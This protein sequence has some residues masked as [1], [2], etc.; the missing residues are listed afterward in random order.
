MIIVTGAE[1]F[2]GSCLVARLNQ[3]GFSDIVLV[4]DFGAI[5]GREKNI[6]GKN[7]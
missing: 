6:E 5:E 7:F 3:E 2:I 1:G 4:D